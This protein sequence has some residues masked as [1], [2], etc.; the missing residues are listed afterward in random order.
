MEGPVGTETI[1]ASGKLV[2][3][4]K[5]ESLFEQIR[6]VVTGCFL[7]GESSTKKIRLQ[8]LDC[9][10]TRLPGQD[11]QEISPGFFGC[12]NTLFS[13]YTVKYLRTTPFLSFM[14]FSLSVPGLH[15]FVGTHLTKTKHLN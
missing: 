1:Y 12:L 13:D 4:G 7:Y 8:L 10:C 6:S 11:R 15:L 9:V 14:D 5:F 2:I 3:P